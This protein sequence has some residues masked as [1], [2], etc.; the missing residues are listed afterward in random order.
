MENRVILELD[1][2]SRKLPASKWGR[3]HIIAYR[4]TQHAG[5]KILPILREFAPEPKDLEH[6]DEWSNIERLVNGPSKNDLLYKSHLEL[7]QEN[8]N[9]GT[10]WSTLAKC[11]AP[12]EPVA[13]NERP[14]R[15]TQQVQTEGSEPNSSTETSSSPLPEAATQS[16]DQSFVPNSSDGSEVGEDDQDD[17]TKSEVIT[18]NLAGA[19][20]RY[21]LNFCAGQKP[22][23]GQMLGF[24]EEPVREQFKLDSITIDATDDGGI[25]EV[26]TEEPGKDPWMWKRRLAL[27]EAKKAFQRIDDDNKPVTSDTNW[28][29]YTCEALTACLKYPDQN[30]YIS[31]SP[32]LSDLSC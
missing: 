14:R 7:E 22:A 17:S 30:E 18:A 31:P 29:Q 6:Q 16:P 1:E 21:V 12:R 3:Q 20:I 11:I 10:L 32:P 19:F 27:L 4:L 15:E 13:Q 25:W 26:G 9:L 28:S 8:G 5:G 24:R 2:K 23:A